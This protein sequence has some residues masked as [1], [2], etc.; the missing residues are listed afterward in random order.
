MKFDKRGGKVIRDTDKTDAPV[1]GQASLS[2]I[3]SN[4]IQEKE[5]ANILVNKD[6]G[7]L[8][9]P[10]DICEGL[11]G[12][13]A[14]EV[15]AIANMPPYTFVDSPK[16]A[17]HYK[18]MVVN[19][20][21]VSTASR[22]EFYNT[23]SDRS[24]YGKSEGGVAR[25]ESGKSK[26]LL[27]NV[28]FYAVI[29]VLIFFLESTLIA[30]DEATEPRNIAGFSPMTILSNSM[31]SV[32]PKDTFILTRQVDPKTLNIGDDITFITESQRT[33][34]HRIVGIE[35]NHLRTRERGFVTK[36]VD[37][38]REDKDMVHA[39]NVIG[40]VV[41]SSHFLG[42]VLLFIRNNLIIS[43][44]IAVLVMLLLDEVVKFLIMAFKDRKR[45]TKRQLRG[46]TAKEGL[47]HEVEV[48]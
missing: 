5:T 11:N 33:V 22:S 31:R 12:K 29:V 21:T 43:V 27:S 10:A 19:K 35:E 39:R 37:N 4:T 14:E 7:A 8:N 34:T 40:K 32:Y 16:D 47:T 24:E 23:C 48:G 42:R 38:P 1:Q 20:I 25:K 2:R 41:F 46:V 13:E 17:K 6:G 15:A 28:I 36:G 45:K 26:K 3:T 44:V 18:T 30:Q 9:N